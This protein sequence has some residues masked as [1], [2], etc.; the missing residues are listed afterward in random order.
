MIISYFANHIIIVQVPIKQNE[1]LRLDPTNQF[2]I[3][4]L[5]K[6]ELLIRL[7]INYLKSVS[8]SVSF[9]GHVQKDQDVGLIIIVVTADVV[10][11]GLESV[12]D[13]GLVE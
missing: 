8:I 13:G 11:R 5:I 6:V 1:H 12:H 2:N 9:S 4:Q 7:E 3:G 10:S